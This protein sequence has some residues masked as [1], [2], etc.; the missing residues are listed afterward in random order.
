MQ[1]AHRLSP[2]SPLRFFGK[3][4]ARKNW[5]DSLQFPA[6]AAVKTKR[7][8]R[9]QAKCDAVVNAGQVAVKI[10]QCDTDWLRTLTGDQISAAGRGLLAEHLTDIFTFI[11]VHHRQ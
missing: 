7:G 9:R 8:A 1:A 5:G 2:G 6:R 10:A 11:F 3:E 4:R